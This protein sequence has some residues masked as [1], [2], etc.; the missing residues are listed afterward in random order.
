LTGEAAASFGALA[1]LMVLMFCYGRDVVGVSRAFT[2]VIADLEVI[3][4]EVMSS[5]I[6]SSES[7]ARETRTCEST[8]NRYS[9]HLREDARAYV[10]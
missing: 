4:G 8:V 9:Y 6:G 3:L 5:Q 7:K 10:R 2:V 1:E